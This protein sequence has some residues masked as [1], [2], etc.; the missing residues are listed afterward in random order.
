MWGHLTRWKWY[1]CIIW[2][3]GTCTSYF[4]KLA[5]GQKGGPMIITKIKICLVWQIGKRV[6]GRGLLNGW[7]FGQLDPPVLVL[8]SGSVLYL[9][10]EEGGVVCIY[11][12]IRLRV[13]SWYLCL[14]LKSKSTHLNAWCLLQC[15]RTKHTIIRLRW[16]NVQ[17][18]FYRQCDY[19][20]SIPPFWRH[21]S[22]LCI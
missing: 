2:G 18:P 17:L 7:S 8:V 21:C 12:C 11:V 13:G 4:G 6:W 10:L 22:D 19:K 15:N 3:Q 16:Y 20:L 1:A 14:S 9:Y 5:T